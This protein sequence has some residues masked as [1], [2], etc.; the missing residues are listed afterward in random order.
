MRRLATG[1]LTQADDPFAAWWGRDYEGIYYANRFL[2]NDLGF[3]TRF[4]TDREADDVLRRN[5]Q[6]EA[7]ALRAW[8]QYDLL[9]KWGGRGTDGRLLG[10][11]IVLE[12]VDVFDADA[13]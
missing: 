6:G 5:L 11:P 8:W 3:N 1:S 2:H 9:R 4:L 13:G 7:Y 12:P 10:F